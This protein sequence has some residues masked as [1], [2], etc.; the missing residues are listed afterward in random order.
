MRNAQPLKANG[1]RQVFARFS[2]LLFTNYLI[3]VDNLYRDLLLTLLADFCQRCQKSLILCRQT[4]AHTN[5]IW[6]AIFSNR[7][8]DNALL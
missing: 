2:H 7:P 6:Q 5:M 4:D 8:N 3:E 1:P